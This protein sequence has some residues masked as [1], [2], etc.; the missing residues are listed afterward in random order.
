MT[1]PYCWMYFINRSQ[2][3]KIMDGS[4]MRLK[5]YRCP[6]SLGCMNYFSKSI[7]R[8]ETARI[9]ESGLLTDANPF[10]TDLVLAWLHKW[11]KHPERKKILSHIESL[12]P[13]GVLIPNDVLRLIQDYFYRKPGNEVRREEEK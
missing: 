11:C 12:P 5:P 3:I 1:T 2:G 13:M 10:G 4:Y 9:T 7:F 6:Y 8:E